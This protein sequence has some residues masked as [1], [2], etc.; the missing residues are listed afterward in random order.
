MNSPSEL[1]LVLTRRLAD[2]T[3]EWIPLE[4]TDRLAVDP[5]A[6][7]ALIDRSNYEAPDSLVVQKQG[8]D[9]LLQVEGA[10]VLTLEGFFT[11]SGA[12]FHPT[13]DIASGAG[14]FS[15]APLTAESPVLSEGADGTQ[16]VFVSNRDGNNEI[17]VMNADGSGQTRLTTAAGNDEDPVWSPD[18]TKIAF[19]S[20]RDGNAEIYVMNADGSGQTRLTTDRNAPRTSPATS[21]PRRS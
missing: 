17:Y 19:K 4:D 14:P 8:D 6:A 9:L 2:G 5:D 11:V 3:I 10:D 15:S 18:G 7:Y 1:N 20:E 16:I 13:T 21:T 12:A